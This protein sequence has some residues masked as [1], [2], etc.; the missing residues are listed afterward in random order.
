MIK[1]LLPTVLLVSISTGFA[2]GASAEDAA[3]PKPCTAKKFHFK[4]VEK[5]CKDGGQK[6]AKTMMKKLVKKAKAAGQDINCKSCHKSLKTF[7]HTP[8]AEKDLAALLKL[9]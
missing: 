3:A 4:E 1:H 7:E 2:M 6:G 5:A 9:K 8:N